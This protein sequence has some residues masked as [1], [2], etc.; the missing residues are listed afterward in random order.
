MAFAGMT[1]NKCIVLRIGTLNGCLLCRE[2]HPLCRLKNPTVISIWLLVGFH[3]ATRSVQS[4]P[5]DTGNTRKRVWQYIE[6]ERK[7]HMFNIGLYRENMKNSSCLKLQGR[8]PLYLVCSITLWT[9]YQ[10][11][12]NYAPGAK[13]APPISN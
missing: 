10:V 4:T 3:P 6:K 13:T 12:S 1:L 7:A 5:A 8:E 11:Y 9:L 2:S